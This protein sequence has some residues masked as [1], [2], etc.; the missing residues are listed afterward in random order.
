VQDR[1]AQKGLST[2]ER[3]SQLQISRDKRIKKLAVQTAAQASDLEREL[4]P[5][6]LGESRDGAAAV[7]ASEMKGTAA[8][9]KREGDRLTAGADNVKKALEEST[10]AARAAA[11][12]ATNDA[13]V[14]TQQH[15]LEQ[16]QVQQKNYEAA[17]KGL[18]L[19][20]QQRTAARQQR[21]STKLRKMRMH[22]QTSEQ[23]LAT[24]L[25]ALHKLMTPL[26][27]MQQ[28]T[29]E[30]GDEVATQL[31]DQSEEEQQ[32][33]QVVSHT[34]HELQENV[35]PTTA[36]EQLKL[37]LAASSQDASVLSSVVAQ[38]KVVGQQLQQEPALT[39]NELH[40]ARDVENSAKEAVKPLQQANEQ[41][42]QTELEEASLVASIKQVPDAA[43]SAAALLGEAQRSPRTDLLALAHAQRA[44]AVEKQQQAEVVHATKIHNDMKLQTIAANARIRAREQPRVLKNKLARADKSLKRNKVAIEKDR[45]FVQKILLPQLRAVKQHAK[46][47]VHDVNE[48]IDIS[49]HNIATIKNLH[50]QRTSIIG[51]ETN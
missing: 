3:D 32:A 49:S 37:E 28:L 15:A 22:L 51:K 39:K 36:A 20:Q 46:A 29:V 35:W 43:D 9:W 50:L 45:Q 23:G 25:D 8:R 4:Q 26:R 16:Q 33:A 30:A 31:S 24:Q 5:A 40:E 21:L 34:E 47:T 44:L 13:I 7:R 48:A 18:E 12:R 2:L 6:R 41:L 11:T 14:A 19:K 27:A 10:S 42:K 1:S 38:T 17:K